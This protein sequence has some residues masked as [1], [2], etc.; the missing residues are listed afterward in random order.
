MHSGLLNPDSSEAPGLSEARRVAQEIA[1]APTV[2]PG[3]AKTAIIFDYD[4]DFSW[5]IQPHGQNMTYFDLV[6][7]SYRAARALGLSIDILPHNSGEFTNYKL[8]LVPGMIHMSDR[9]KAEL[10]AGGATVIIGP[11]S[12]SRTQYMQIPVPLPPNLPGLD[13]T[14]TQVGSLRP[15]MGI[16][17][18]KGGHFQHYYEHLAGAAQVTERTTQEQPA[19]M[20]AGQLHYLA[21]WPDPQA[22]QRILAA[23]CTEVAIAT[24]ALPKGLRLRDT[25]AEKF[26]FNYS[27]ETQTFE[28][29]AFAPASV[30]RTPL[31]SAPSQ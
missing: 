22:F 7:E 19:M 31:P 25:A 26:W 30:L 14:V 13:A 15:G 21:G 16:A 29:K 9:L 23:A 20:C 6:F 8:I 1:A 4:A 10:A 12:A 24:Y 3:R 2:V 5:S 28:G 18:E 27:A 11:R 17:L